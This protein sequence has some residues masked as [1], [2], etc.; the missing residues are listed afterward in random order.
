LFIF[1][2]LVM[3]FINFTHYY[4][5]TWPLN[6]G[7]CCSETSVGNYQRTQSKITEERKPQSRSSNSIFTWSRTWNL[8]SANYSTLHH[9]FKY[10]LMFSFGTESSPTAARR[11]GVKSNVYPQLVGKFHPFYRPRRPLGRADV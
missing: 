11:Q 8:F 4:Q 3:V 9:H 10:I 5:T 7:I 1:S 6:M 2:A